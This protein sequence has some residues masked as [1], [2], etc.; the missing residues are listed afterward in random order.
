MSALEILL[1]IAVIVGVLALLW[2]AAHN[3]TTVC[4]IEITE[5]HVKVVRGGIAPG[6]LGDIA[7]VVRRPV[8]ARATVRITRE[9]GRAV[10]EMTGELSAD[11][12]Q[13]LRNVIGTV[14]LARLAR[15][16]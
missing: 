10:V 3:A 4:V 8:V 1:A 7:D 2:R 9:S 5:G 11:Q 14:P 6:V 12:R 13:Q 15:K 16:R